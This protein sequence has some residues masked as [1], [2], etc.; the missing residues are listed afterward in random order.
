VLYTITVL[1]TAKAGGR[2]E[3]MV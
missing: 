2:D 1:I 3:E